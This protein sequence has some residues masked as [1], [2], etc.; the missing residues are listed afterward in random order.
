MKEKRHIFLLILIAALLCPAY[1]RNLEPA[2]EQALASLKPQHLGI[3]D[4]KLKSLSQQ[5]GNRLVVVMN[6]EF[7]YLPFRE[8]LV[9]RAYDTVRSILPKNLKHKKLAIYAGGYE[10][11]RLIPFAD[12]HK[13]FAV[14]CHRPIVEPAGRL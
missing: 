8:E 4:I 1:A 9:K 10:I 14:N 11:S 13:R 6:D 2:V 7:S 5:K 3:G 12:S